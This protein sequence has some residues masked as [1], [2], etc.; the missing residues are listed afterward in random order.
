MGGRFC[1]HDQTQ[2]ECES[3]LEEIMSFR[4]RNRVKTKNKRFSPKIEEFLPSKSS[5]DQKK[6]FS[7]QFGTKFGQNL[8]DLVVL[9]GPFSS[10][11]LALK[12]RRR[13]AKS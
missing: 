2:L 12:P 7:S 8:W 5:E 6:R 9:P 4:P 1:S 13:D 10:V 3:T 11:Q